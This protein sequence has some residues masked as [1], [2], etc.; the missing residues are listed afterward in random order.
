MSMLLGSVSFV[1]RGGG[2]VIRIVPEER[3]EGARSKA[4][5]GL[6]CWG[7]VGEEGRKRRRWP[8]P[9]HVPKQ[10]TKTLHDDQC[11]WEGRQPPID[12]IR[13]LLHWLC[14]NSFMR[15]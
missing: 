2:D 4:V 11:T 15:C 13:N 10:R 6:H 1:E 3:G 14:L 8:S 9:R 5:R 7:G 12:A